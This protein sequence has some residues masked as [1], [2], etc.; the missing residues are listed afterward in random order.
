[1]NGLSSARFPLPHGKLEVGRSEVRGT[2]VA[3]CAI[4]IVATRAIR[5]GFVAT[6]AFGIGVVATRA[7]GIVHGRGR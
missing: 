5:I 4:G 7:F 1:V 6:R 2:L 3:A